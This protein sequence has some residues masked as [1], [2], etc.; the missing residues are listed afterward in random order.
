MPIRQHIQRHKH[1]RTYHKTKYNKAQH[2]YF[3]S[4]KIKHNSEPYISYRQQDGHSYALL[5]AAR[6]PRLRAAREVV[7]FGFYHIV[8]VAKA[9]QLRIEGKEQDRLESLHKE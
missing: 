5:R 2:F 9:V 3:S 8:A 1:I 6:A 4:N 7:L